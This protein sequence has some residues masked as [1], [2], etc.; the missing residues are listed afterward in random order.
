MSRTMKNALISAVVLVAIAVV[1]VV[2]LSLANAFFPKYTPTLN[3][4]KIAQLQQVAQVE[5]DD[6][7]A[8]GENYYSII[9]SDEFDLESFNKKN[10][11]LGEVLAVYR[12]EKGENKGMII[13]ETKTVG[14][15]SQ[16]STLMTSYKSD[17]TIAGLIK[18]SDG[19]DYLLT[20]KNI[21]NQ[22]KALQEAVIG[23]K[24][25]TADE[26]KTATGATAKSS[27]SGIEK[28]LRLSSMVAVILLGEDA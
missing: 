26:I 15:G 11:S 17:A 9:G 1:S 25:M 28:N 19:G 13:T 14:Y 7:T 16:N 8:L 22:Y 18:L 10:K 23:K 6:N 2:L 4:Q 21:A 12:V 27:M 5:A 24:A 20:D 3:M